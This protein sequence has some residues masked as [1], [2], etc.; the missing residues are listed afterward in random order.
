MKHFLPVLP[1]IALMTFWGCEQIIRIDEDDHESK[2]VVWALM[3]KDSLPEVYIQRNNPIAG[4]IEQEPSA[5]F[6]KGLPVE[7]AVDGNSQ[8]LTEKQKY[9]VGEYYWWDIP[10][11]LLVYFYGSEEKMQ[12]GKTYT[13][14]FPFEDK[15][16]SATTF[17]PEPVPLLDA[18]EVYIT[19]VDPIDG[20]WEYWAMRAKFKDRAGE[21]NAY[22]I[23]FRAEGFTSIPVFDPV[24]GEFLRRDSIYQRFV[25]YSDIITDENRDGQTLTLDSRSPYAPMEYQEYIRP[26]GSTGYGIQYQIRLQVMDRAAGKFLQ[27]L[28]E[29]QQNSYDP[30]A[31]AVF[32]KSNIENGLGVFAGFNLSD[33]LMI[34]L[35]F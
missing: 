4:W 3:G 30:L 23:Q 7:M 34:W 21:D 32:L 35:G 24:T 9:Y 1:V 15:T 12:T 33:T 2:A 28:T 17:I 19:E 22:R 29:Q 31:E 20:V 13:L 10:D 5:R 11:S 25:S 27:S 16:V 14:S 8:L 18:E 6:E 26:D